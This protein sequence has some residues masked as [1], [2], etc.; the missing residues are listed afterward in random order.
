M[1]DATNLPDFFEPLLAEQYSR[2]HSLSPRQTVALKRVVMAYRTQ[3]PD[4]EGRTA[5]IDLSAPAAAAKTTDAP[6]DADASA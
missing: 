2:R 6:N 3:I 4:F 1:T 5:G